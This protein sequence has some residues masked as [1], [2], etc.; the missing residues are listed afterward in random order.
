[1]IDSITRQGCGWVVAEPR[2]QYRITQAAQE[3]NQVRHAALREVLENL[4]DKRQRCVA[5]RGELR[6]ESLL[7]RQCNEGDAALLAFAGEAF[8]AFREVS[9]ST[10]HAH[11]QCPAVGQLLGDESIERA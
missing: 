1:M 3:V 5:E 9:A 6:I 2:H 11:N 8:E 10:Q 4:C 7:T